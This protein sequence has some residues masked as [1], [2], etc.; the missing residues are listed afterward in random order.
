[1]LNESVSWHL[2]FMQTVIAV[3]HL[4]A[5]GGVT[6][7][8]LLLLSSSDFLTA[9]PVPLFCFVR[10]FQVEQHFGQKKKRTYTKTNKKLERS[11][12]VIRKLI[13]C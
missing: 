1:M 2:L 7:Q 6:R 8:S 10:G 11:N 5:C 9:L 3:Q 4:N 12:V 13:L